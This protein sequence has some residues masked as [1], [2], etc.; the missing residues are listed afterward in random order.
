MG[1]LNVEKKWVFPLVITSLVCVLL[2]ATS[3]NMGLASSL[4][5]INSIF[6]LFPSR[7]MTNQ[8]SPYYVVTKIKQAPPPPTGPSV[9]KFAYLISG[10][11]GDL[12]KLWRTLQAL[13]HPQ[14]YYVIHL[15]LESPPEERLELA[16][17]VEKD[18]IFA[19]VGN[20]YMNAKANMVTYRGPTMVSNTLHAC[21]ILLK[22]HKDWDWF[23]NLS[24]SDYPLVTQ[25]DLLYTFSNLKR[26]L[27]FIE[28]TSR[29]GWKVGKRAMPLIVDP[30]LYQKNKSD[31][32]LARPRRNLPTAFNLYTGSAWMILS[33]AFVEYCIWGWDNLPRNLLMYYTNFVSSPEGYFQTVICN[34]PE[35]VPTVVNHDMHYISWDIPPKQH[36]RTLSL[37]DTEKMI[38]S[39][40]AFARKFKQNVPVLDKIDKELLGRENGSFT[41]GGW[42]A[43]NPPCSEVGNPTRLKPGRGAQRLQRLLGKLVLSDN[44]SKNQCK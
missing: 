14:N 32:F 8:S 26:E 43:G 12:E 24:A 21:A 20:V 5:T 35:F 19:K 33:R 9:P 18:P 16:S 3:F 2:F 22:R 6:P 38:A 41:Q 39:G 44:F 13:Y 1:N 29:L 37:N 25:D 42:C 11:K 36:P 31:I 34:A 27:N 7:V 10:S 28:H 4:H 23:I 15:D 17:R 30:G 40:A